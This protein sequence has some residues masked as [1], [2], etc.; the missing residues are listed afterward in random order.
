MQGVVGARCDGQLVAD[1]ADEHAVGGQVHLVDAAADER[2]V[3]GQRQLDHRRLALLELEQAHEVT[4]AD[5]LLDERRHEPRRRDGDV[6]APAVVEHPLVLRVVDACDGARHAEL[7]LGEQR[8]DEIDLVVTGRADDDV[9]C[10]ELGLVQRRDLARVGEQPGGLRNRL[11]AGLA[12][13]LV[14]E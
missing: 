11:H 12:S 13:V 2:R 3:S 6:D 10:L 8:D 7:G 14:D 5:G 4:D 9:G 1:D